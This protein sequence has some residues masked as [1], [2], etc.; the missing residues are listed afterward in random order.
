MRENHC[1]DPAT[2][3]LL[4]SYCFEQLVD[5]HRESLEQ[6]LLA[7][8]RC[9]R[10]LQVLEQSVRVLR[11]SPRIAPALTPSQSAAVF[12][13]SG[14]LSRPLGGHLTFVVG[15]TLLYALL[16]TIGLWSELGYAYERFGALAARL[17]G[18]VAGVIATIL[19][20][21]FILDVRLTRARNS[22]AF[23]F[24]A[25][26]AVAAL[27]AVTAALV[28]ILPEE[29]TI[30]ASFATRTASAGYFKDALHIFFPPLIFLLPTFHMIL[31]LQRELEAGR[32]HEVLEFVARR[33]HATAPRGAPYVPPGVLVAVLLVDGTLKIVGA[34]RMLDA[35]SPGPYAH[36][37]TMA[38]YAS[39]GAWFAI[40]IGSLAWYVVSL[41]E[42]K[43]EA[44]RASK[45][46]RVR[47]SSQPWR[48]Q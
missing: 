46:T 37:F 41:N 28:W 47:R 21:V 24:T 27:A 33:P 13:S 26:G 12:G 44:V 36:V 32:S 22:R 3:R 7:C 35:L 15:M 39:T 18:P 16:W 45:L 20:A 6:H 14:R 19:L 29:R 5:A 23:L 42:V 2:G 30:Q 1:T 25:I 38:S 17:S 40:T 8:D 9:W 11:T 10:D 31:A 43:R 34:N 48:E 4:T